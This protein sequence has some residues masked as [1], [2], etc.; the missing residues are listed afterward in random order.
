MPRA[1]LGNTFLFVSELLFEARELAVLQLGNLAVVVFAFGFFDFELGL[2]DVSLDFR[3]LSERALLG[4]PL[5]GELLALLFRL[6]QLLLDFLESI[7][8]CNVGLAIERRALDFE[9]HHAPIH[10]IELDR[11]RFFFGAQLGRGLID[12]VDCLVRQKSIGDVAR[13]QNRRGHQ[14]GILDADAVVNFVALLEPAQN[15]DSVLDARL[16]DHHGLEAAFERRILLDVLAIFVERGRA[17]AMQFAARQHRLEQIGGIHRAL[18]RARADDRMQLV[19]EE[20]DLALGLLDFLEHRL[21]AFLELT[22]ELRA[23]NQRAHVEGDE[24]T[25]LKAVGHVAADDALGEALDNR[26]L[27]D[28]RL[29]DQH[30]II[31]GPA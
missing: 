18:R 29:A 25:I 4:F 23:R 12:E 8:G 16:I 26:G 30:R 17:D 2:L 28:A 24:S 9:L 19:D 10:F 20:D 7:L 13:R 11:H 31:L 14:R 3:E 27:A 15:R 22:A 1:L 6:G 5:R 21:Q